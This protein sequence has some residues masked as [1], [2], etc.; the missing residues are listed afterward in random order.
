MTTATQQ[1]QTRPVQIHVAAAPLHGD[2]A[3]P[4]GRASG[5]VM[6]AHGSGSSRHSPRNRAVAEQLNRNGFATLL[7][8]LLTRQEEQIDLGSGKI[9]FNVRLLADRLV[10]ATDWV[11]EQPDLR[12]LPVG[13]F[14]ASTGAA[15][16]LVAAAER[17]ES[18]GAVVSR[19]GRPDLAGGSLDRV[20][21][22]T[23]LIVGGDD[24]EI[25]ALNEAALRGLQC[26]KKL[27]IVA[28]ATHLF[29]ESGA[30]QQV[31]TLAAEWFRRYLPPLLGQPAEGADPPP[32]ARYVPR[33]RRHAGEPWLVIA[34]AS[35]ARILATRDR[36]LEVIRELSDAAG[37]AHGR[38]F[39]PDRPGRIGKS[40]SHS[41]V[42]ALD[43]H[44][45]PKQVE[46]EAFAREI[47]RVLDEGH[48]AHAFDA[49]AL[50]A[51]PHFLG[52]LRKSLSPPV[53]RTVLTS[54]HKE[55][56]WAQP[57]ELSEHLKDVIAAL[58]VVG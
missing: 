18:T 55:L 24:T 52:L 19:G 25:V 43:R 2:L 6:F 44:T 14:G 35:R 1:S 17:P 34:D 20:S 48:S 22:P 5:I 12:A 42:S 16:A 33:R 13:Y 31:A 41:S 47:A 54:A 30:L 45:P 46:A 58:K 8:D 4:S 38:A 40:A 32:G 27:S 15:A 36:Q 7:L 26:D 29:E 11:C 10:A 28:G 37:R 50:V 3:F 9:R 53:R 56:T 57:R 39:T 49:L 51:P 21:A 23:L